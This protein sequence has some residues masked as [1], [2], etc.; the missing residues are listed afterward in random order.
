VYAALVLVLTWNAIGFLL[1]LK[2]IRGLVL[3]FTSLQK[4]RAL[5]VIGVL[6]LLNWAYRLMLDLH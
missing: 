4:R 1:G 6:I 5:V 3:R 2:I